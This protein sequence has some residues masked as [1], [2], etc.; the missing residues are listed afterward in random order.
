MKSR[1]TDLLAMVVLITSTGA[2]GAQTPVP[3]PGFKEVVSL[4]SAGNPVIS[5]DGRH[6]AYTVRNADWKENRFRT[7]IYLAREGEAPVQLTRAAKGNS[8]SPRWSPDGEWLAFVSDRADKQQV[9]LIRP[10]G[11]EAMQVTWAK[12][13]VGDFRWAP[14]GKRIA[15]TAT[16]PE[17]DWATKRKSL[18]GDFAVEG[19]E[20]RQSHLWVTEVDPLTWSPDSTKRPTPTRLTEG[21]DFT[22]SNFAWSPDGTRLAIEERHDPLITSSVSANI[23][24]LNVATKLRTPLVTTVG[25][26]GS[27]L[28]SPDGR[29]ILYSSSGGDTTSNFYRNGEMLKISEAGGAPVRL[30]AGF[31]EQIGNVSWTPNGIYFLAFQKA[32]RSLWLIPPGGTEAVAVEQPFEWLGGLDITADGHFATALVQSRTTLGEVYRLD[33]EK[34]GSPVKLTDLSRQIAAWSL[35]T[36]EMVSWKSRDGAVIEGVLHKPKDFDPRKKYP[37]LVVIHGGPTGIDLPVPPIPGY[38]YPISEWVAKGALVLRPNYRGSAGYGERFRALNVRN[39][40]VGDMWD[41][42]SGVDHLIKQGIVDTTRMGSMGWSQGGYISAFLTTHTN[43]FKAISVGAGI[44]DWKTYYVST[45]I[46]PFT[47][48]YL[49]ATPWDDPAIYAKTSP[50]ATI[51]QARTPTLIQHGSLDQRVPISDAYE[52]YQ[53]LQ[54]QLVP[55]KLIVYQGFGHGI[56]KPKEQLAL[57]WHN[58]EWFGKYVFGETVEIPLEEGVKALGK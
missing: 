36:N 44:S 22:V 55:T 9:Y 53:G 23:S 45:D 7:E 14:D 3:G 48:Q 31:D 29:W 40:G 6:V 49:K 12:D 28:W 8:T 37:L 54:D 52:L 56:N 25:F 33:L 27:P 20:Y 51:K 17:D 34:A 35:P 30:A 38:A 47:R 5:P 57:F 1:R 4:E 32:K 58:W 43:R 41:V 11:G 10:R 2:L 42:M 16:E 21:K 50:M 13:G 24:L 39:L 46:H 26:D 15:Y 19:A 18:Y